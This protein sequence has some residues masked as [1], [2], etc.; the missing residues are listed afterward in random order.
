M[1]FFKVEDAAISNTRYLAK[2][3]EKEFVHSGLQTIVISDLIDEFVKIQGSIMN[4]IQVY[5]GIGLVVGIAGLG[6]VAIRSVVERRQEIGVMRAIGFKKRMVGRSF[7]TEISFISLTG[8]FAGI[9][10]GVALSFHI[11]RDFFGMKASFVDFLGMIPVMNLVIIA[12]IAF[13]LTI[14]LTISSAFKAAKIVPAE[15]LRFK[16]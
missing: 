2:E 5:L 12:V 9:L 13:V 10:L 8:I 1:F 4:L 16:E 7:L 14:L 11:Y 15:A 6:I 3:L